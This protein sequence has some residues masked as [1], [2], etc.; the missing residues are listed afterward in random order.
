MYRCVHVLNLS[1]KVS[2]R[3]NLTKK[4]SQ[5]FNGSWELIKRII[6]LIFLN[7]KRYFFWNTELNKNKK[8]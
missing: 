3:I 8:I 4:C 2:V 1:L 5:K 6:Y 7:K